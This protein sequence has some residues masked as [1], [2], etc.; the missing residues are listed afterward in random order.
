MRKVII[1][2]APT[3]S[4]PTREDTPYLPITPDEVADETLR[5]HEAGAAVVHL[6]ARDPESG[7]PTND[8]AVYEAYLERIRSRCDIVTQITTG[9]GAVTMGLTPEQRLEAVERLRPEMASLNAGSMNFGRKLFPNTPDVMELYAR[10]MK[11]WGVTPEFEVYDVGMI[12]N[13]KRWIIGADIMSPPMQFSLVMGVA[14]G[15]PATPRNA[16]FMS[17]ALPDECTWQMIGI[18]R[19]QIPHGL[20]GVLLGGN[21]RVGMEDNIYLAKGELAK[22]NADLVAKIVRLIRELGMEPASPAEAR[23]LLHLK[24]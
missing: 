15:I 21:V 9:G 12:E 13:V 24:T 19:H 8:A 6:H 22:S 5:A 3:G 18:G 23:E 17:E 14:G 16:V 11:E 20:L 1:T 2:V 7:A 10:R 4:I